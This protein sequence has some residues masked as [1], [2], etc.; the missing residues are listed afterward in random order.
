MHTHAAHNSSHN[1][2]PASH[3]RL[4]GAMALTGGV[5][6]AEGIGGYLSGSL[7]LLA[8]AGHMLTDMLALSVAFAAMQLG[9]LP[10][11]DKR[12]FGYRRL[13]VLAALLN[14]IALVGIAGLIV[15]EAVGR[16]WSPSTVA[17][18]PM[19]VVASIGLVAN[20]LGLMLLG[21]QPH[22]F[23]MRSA[24]LHV[25]GDTLSSAA[26][27]VGGLV[28]AC[29]GWQRVDPVLSVLIAVVIAL[30]SYRLLREVVGVLLDAV[31]HGIDLAQVRAAMQSVP[32]VAEIHDLHV[33]S[34][35]QGIPA[36]S[37]HVVVARDR[38][39]PHQVL[40][41][42]QASLHTFAID[43]VTLQIELPSAGCACPVGGH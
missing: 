10:A 22:N 6:I 9:N 23:N 16:W 21:H 24:F 17:L 41:A 12:T 28:M 1:H 19:M 37:A 15:V 32:D 7:A 20:L 8:D 2:G 42:V 39:D 5:V 29:T 35:T 40:R 26:V 13:E 36:L 30:S 3:W 33:W 14:G 25:L 38:A 11:D 18:V 43:H 4:L 27:I 31:P 34:I